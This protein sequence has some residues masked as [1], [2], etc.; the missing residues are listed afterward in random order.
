MYTAPPTG[1]GRT[2]VKGTS[3]LGFINAAAVLYLLLAG[4]WRETNLR[5]H[6]FVFVFMQPYFLLPKM[7][8]AFIFSLSF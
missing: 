3:P 7:V 5:P 4:A 6:R 1:A 8:F 2:L